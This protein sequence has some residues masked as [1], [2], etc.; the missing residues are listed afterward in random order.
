M[1]ALTPWRRTRACSLFGRIDEEVSAK[2]FDKTSDLLV[3]LKQNLNAVLNSRPGCCQSSPTLG[4]IDFND[5]TGTSVDISAS[6][7]L[8]IQQC[9]ENFDPRI[10][11]VDV[12]TF[13][14]ENDPLTLF[15]QVKAHIHFEDIDSVV[16]FNI[17]LDDNSRYQLR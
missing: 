16:N 2:P 14:N 4:V 5:A 8:A 10:K 11:S 3:S 7:C 17:Q 12:A 9:I 6:V 13:N 15:F 1:S